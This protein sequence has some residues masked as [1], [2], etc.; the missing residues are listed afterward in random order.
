MDIEPDEPIGVTGCARSAHM[1]CFAAAFDPSRNISLARTQAAGYSRFV[2]DPL[3]W[4][5][6]VAPLLAARTALFASWPRLFKAEIG[7]GARLT[8]EELVA[9]FG[10]ELEHL[11]A[12]VHPLTQTDVDDVLRSTA[13]CFAKRGVPL[14]EVLTA[15]SLAH[16]AAEQALGAVDR[17]TAIALSA[18]EHARVRAYTRAYRLRVAEQP[19]SC[20]GSPKGRPSGK[21]VGR[22][23][24]PTYGLVGGSKSVQR[25]IGLVE[26]AASGPRTVLI[27]GESGTGKEVVARAIHSAAGGDRK[28]FVAVNCAALPPSLA[29]SEL[30][31]HVR[32]AF[33]GS[34]TEYEGLFRAATGG[35]L[36]LDEVTEMSPEM[37][38]KLLRAIEDRVVRPVGS[39]RE[40]PVDLRILASS[41]RD[42]GTAIAE[43]IF[44]ADLLYRLQGFVIH[45]PPLRDRRDDVR[46]LVDHFLETFCSRRCGCIVGVSVD[47]MHA[48]T[49]YDWPGNV[50]ELRNV[51]EHAVSTGTSKWIQRDDLPA[52]IRLTQPRD[53]PRLAAR[54]SVQPLADAEAQLVRE[55]IAQYSGNKLAAARA[56]GISRHKLYETLKRIKP[57]DAGAPR[58]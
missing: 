17:K 53:E 39:T 27:T 46:L 23:S 9:I 48:L 24:Q 5:E 36:F 37:Q 43:G 40:V 22:V 38:A 8:E 33:T 25:V 1:R 2:V 35:T 55:A 44:R 11:V 18:L 32:G 6:N 14:E 21:A 51:I 49:A 30:F 42:I 31:G 7:P 52:N 13:N 16:D 26:A 54:T 3:Q 56:L 29:E 10:R 12:P 34:A 57:G 41:N 45:L 4:T 19:P 50:R 15:V 47:A 20:S 28:N 58:S